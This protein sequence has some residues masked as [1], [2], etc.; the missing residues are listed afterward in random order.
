MH[1]LWWFVPGL[2]APMLIAIIATIH[3][4]SA[5]YAVGGGIVLAGE[6]AS[7]HRLNHVPYLEYLKSH[8]WFFVFFTVAYGAITGVGIWWTIGLTSPLATETLIHI[9]VF[10]WAMEWVFFILEIVS[11]F[12]FFYYWDRLD[13]K[14]HTIIGWIYAVSAW[15]S[16]VLITGIT[17]FQLNS[18]G[19]Q[20]GDGFWHAFLNPQTIPQILARTGGALVMAALYIYLHASFKLKNNP[21]LLHFVERHTA[22]W[23][24]WGAIFLIVGGLWWRWKLTESAA[25]VLASAGVLNALV[26]ILLAAIVIVFVMAYVGPYKNPQWLTPGFAV[27]IFLIGLGAISAGEFTREAVRK[28]YIVNGLVLGN[29]I[30]QS[31]VEKGQENGFLNLS[32]WAKFYV[33]ENFPN[34][35]NTDG[36][37]VD[38]LLV[39]VPEKEQRAIGKVLFMHHC[40]DCHSIDGFTGLSDLVRGWD[41]DMLESGIEALD[42]IHFFMPEF[43]GTS[44]E[45]QVLAKFIQSVQKPKPANLAAK[46]GAK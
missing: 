5:L 42:Q 35:V 44:E 31:E 22:K 34:V 40:N 4:F 3:M 16:L 26:F 19:W 20:A 15:G 28:P 38:S 25:A 12:T 37:I 11:A 18:G 24:M 2:T 13:P 32:T 27:L 6:T 17:A 8:T 9:F 1:Y 23:I 39:Q 36:Q 30:R 41:Y 33:K 10:G 7:A 46:G 45:A 21:D 14:T 43:A 29:Q